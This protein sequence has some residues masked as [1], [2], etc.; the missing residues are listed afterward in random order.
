[1]DRLQHC[2]DDRKLDSGRA[3]EVIQDSRDDC[4]VIKEPVSF[5]TIY[6]INSFFEEQKKKGILIFSK[7]QGTPNYFYSSGKG[8]YIILTLIFAKKHF[9]LK[10]K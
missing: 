2:N 8:T 1:M 10:H 6:G 4:S 7:K 3:M 9:K 5:G